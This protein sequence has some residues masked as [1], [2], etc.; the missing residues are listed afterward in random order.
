MILADLG[1]DMHILIIQY[2]E[3]CMVGRIA[4]LSTYWRQMANPTARVTSLDLARR[5]R[6]AA[7]R[8]RNILWEFCGKDAR[9]YHIK[10]ACVTYDI[11]LNNLDRDWAM[12]HLTLNPNITIDML[13]DLIKNPKINISNDCS[14]NLG[15]TSFI[16]IDEME[17]HG[18]RVNYV[19]SIEVITLAVYMKH[20]DI[21][22]FRSFMLFGNLT[23]QD[24]ID[25]PTLPWNV[26]DLIHNN[27]IPKLWIAKHFQLPKEGMKELSI[28]SSFGDILEPTYCDFLV[29][30][31]LGPYVNGDAKYL[32]FQRHISCAVDITH[33]LAHPTAKWD[34]YMLSINPHISLDDK[35]NNFSLP[36]RLDIPHLAAR[37]PP[38]ADIH[39]PTIKYLKM[40]DRGKLTIDIVLAARDVGWYWC[41]LVQYLDLENTLRATD[42]TEILKQFLAHKDVCVKHV[43]LFMAKLKC[44]ESILN[45]VKQ[46]L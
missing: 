30:E 7:L 31:V 45:S 32:M 41:G 33:V 16:T 12:T 18:F 38:G 14:F 27:N 25:N 10:H 4:Q 46:P 24:I 22:N 28:L 43:P 11:I 13:A 6:I 5:K 1:R 20:K 17:K 35:L 19:S 23:I 44:G 2:L 29:N 42:N 26:H 8:H 15:K 21:I 37:L 34:W 36:W 3:L 40:A 39:H 9:L